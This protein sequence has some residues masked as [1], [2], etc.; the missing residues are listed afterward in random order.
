M[1]VAPERRRA[2]GIEPFASRDSRLAEDLFTAYSRRIYAYCLSQLRS[3]EEAE[4]AV[5]ATYLN[6]CRSLM[7][8]FEPEAA[9]AWLFKVAQN[10]CLTRRRNRSRWA[11]LE[12]AQD[13]GAVEEIV[14][15]PA[16]GDELVGLEEALAS[17]PERQ[18][19][20][21]LL[22]E[23]QGLSYR[24][25]AD[26]LG[27]SQ[28]AVET[29]IFRARRSLAAALAPPEPSRP[30]L[31]HGLDVGGLLAGLKSA[32]ANGLNGGLATG[33]AIAASTTV[34]AGAPA[35]GPLDAK[36]A[37]R[38]LVVTA[39]KSS[40]AAPAVR[41]ALADRLSFSPPAGGAKVFRSV[42]KGRN[43][44]KFGAGGH[45]R[46]HGK[47]QGRPSWAGSGGPPPHANAGGHGGG[48]GRGRP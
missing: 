3:P 32:M 5:Q 20:A 37:E 4:D 30:R 10:V 31:L 19:R 36:P 29:L 13:L 43:S 18:C 33:A 46:G 16:A 25:V 17:L 45:G 8:G 34:I 24:E 14:P 44:G 21:F 27:V 2:V 39:A 22:R 1:A 7:R 6:A 35:G 38:P 42:D 9:Q 40:P 48:Q 47:G 28:S 23:W 41:P 26:E 11:R 15:A 12:L